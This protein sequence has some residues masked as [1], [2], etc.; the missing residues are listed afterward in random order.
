[1]R[2]R[3][4]T[5]KSGHGIDRARPVAFT[6]DGRSYEGLAGDTLASALIANGVDVVARSPLRG[7]PRGVFSAGVEEPNAFVELSAPVFRPIVP[8]TTV[9]LVD[10]L[11]AAPRP[12]V[13]RL[14]TDDARA[15]AA[16]HRH[17][18]V[19]TLV[20]GAGL[21]G[22]R[23]T[24]DAARA[25][26]RVMLVDERPWV[27]GTV[28]SDDDVDGESALAYVATTSGA[29]ASASEVTVLSDATALGIYDDGYVVV[30]E[31][32]TPVEV[33]HHVR[34]K[35]VVLASGAHERPIAFA[36]NDLP[37]VMLASA[38]HLYADRFGVVAGERAVVF[39]TNHAGHRAAMALARAGLDIVAIV[40]PGE[41]GHATETSRAAGIDVRSGWAVSAADGDARVRSVTIDGAPRR[42]RDARR[43]PGARLRRVESCSATLARHRRWPAL[44][45]GMRVLRSRRARAALALGRR[46]CSRR[47]SDERSVLVLAERRSLRAFRR[48]AARLDRRRRARGGRPRAAIDRARE[49]RDLHRHRDRSGPHERRAHRRHRESSL[50]RGARCTGPDEQPAPVHACPLLGAR[51]DRPR[52]GAAR[53]DP[54]DADARSARR[55]RRSLRERRPMEAPLVL[56]PRRRV[57]AR[58]GRAR[59]PRRSAYGRGH[60]R[61]H[62]R[63][64]RARR[65]RHGDVPR[66][67]LHEPHVDARRGLDPVRDHARPRR[68]GL[69]RRCR[70]A[71]GGRSIPDHDDH[72]RCRE[73]HGSPGRVAADRMAGSAGVL[74]RA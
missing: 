36:R 66:P 70:D 15:P 21:A 30:H 18:H 39:S 62:A 41:G 31:R 16:R 28:T 65:P 26:D 67:A 37:G 59:V 13:G 3:R 57:D 2:G 12:G 45:R 14:P 27:G 72:R 48:S 1:M 50:G 60:G 17:A 55:T 11:D 25:G 58:R 73:G 19:E 29:L 74:R 61:F 22:L 52:T 54:H 46:C 7:R 43:R 38:A 63:Q 71:P 42:K 40:D 68:H 5:A 23:V 8:A 9:S 6:F 32:S 34:A 51:R 10:G 64:D 20:I 53:S 4:L 47:G 35:R 44:A 33:V 49:A 56:P 69:R 24:L